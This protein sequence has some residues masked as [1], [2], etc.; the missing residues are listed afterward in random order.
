MIKK[1]ITFKVQAFWDKDA[2]V[3]VATSEDVPGLAT[4]AFSMEILTQK[5]RVMIPELIVLNGIIPSDYVG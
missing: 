1:E 4:E 5:L 2:E 3:W